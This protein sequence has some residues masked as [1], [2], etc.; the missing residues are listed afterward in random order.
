MHQNQSKKTIKIQKMITVF[1]LC[2]FLI[3]VFSV[4]TFAA[5]VTVSEE[6]SISMEDI[7]NSEVLSTLKVV[8][9][10]LVN[11]IAA[12]A[13]SMALFGFAFSNGQK[14]TENILKT[15]KAITIAFVIL[16]GLG[17]LLSTIGAVVGTHAYVFS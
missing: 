6:T 11:P 14:Q 17:L 12:V 16:N 8:V 13:M 9:V 5:T 10:T 7:L 4:V 3:S 2:F 15:V 1:C